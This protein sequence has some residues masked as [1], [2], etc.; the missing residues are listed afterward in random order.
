V[1]EINGHIITGKIAPLQ[2]GLPV[3][4][5]ETYLSVPGVR[6]QFQAASAD[7]EGKIKFEMKNFY[8]EG[9][10]IAQTNAE[11]D[12]LYRIDINSPFFKD[13][14]N[15]PLSPFNF[16]I[17][18]KLLLNRYIAEQVQN[19]FSYNKLNQSTVSTLDTTSFYLQ[20]SATY[21]L[22]NYVRFTTLE[23]V[24]REYV[25][26]VGVRQHSGKYLLPVFDDYNKLPFE[27]DPLVL[28]DGVPIFN[29]NKLLKYDPA[30]IRKLE[31]INTR[32]YLG[33]NAFDG[34][35]NLTS[36]KGDITG[37]EI[38]PHATVLDYEGLQLQR[39]FYSPVYNTD[40][41][42]LNRLPD[43]RTLLYWSPKVIT[44][45]TGKTQEGFYSSDLPGKYAIVIQGITEDGTAGSKVT[46]FDVKKN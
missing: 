37:A 44:N 35:V 11:A 22:D 5:I 27:T 8:S 39:E 25:P 6:P 31:V 46:F 4:D 33:Q 21:L 13:F 42:R 23:E 3:K 12:S 17:N 28:V 20:P 15:K 40:Q 43:F 36:Y 9:E 10:I 7:G 19:T 1:P 29:I 45:E 38:D 30:K 24:F 32:Y 18:K 16:S 26:E 2:N 14:T 34:I 41:Q